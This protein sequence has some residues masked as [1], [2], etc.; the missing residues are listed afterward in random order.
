MVRQRQDELGLRDP[1]QETPNDQQ[2][3][4]TDRERRFLE[5]E[6]TRLSPTA[7]DPSKGL[8]AF[9]RHQRKRE[10]R[11]RCTKS[12][13]GVELLIAATV[14]RRKAPCRADER[15]DAPAAMAEQADYSGGLAILSSPARMALE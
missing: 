3:I 15:S 7:S 2:E 4:D 6:E 13:K 14:R 5:A 1:P 10:S 9:G 12:R 11:R 8:S